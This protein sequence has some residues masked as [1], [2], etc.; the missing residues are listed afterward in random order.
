MK[1]DR[2]FHALVVVVDDRVEDRLFLESADD[3]HLG[4][5]LV[6]AVQR[7]MA[8]CEERFPFFVGLIVGDHFL[9]A[10]RV[11]GQTPGGQRDGLVDDT[12]FH[13]RID[14]ADEAGGITAGVR[15][16]FA[17]DDVLPVFERQ[18]R[19]PVVPGRIRAVR[20]RGVDDLRL[21]V[22]DELH[23]FNGG[24]VRQTQEHEVCR[25]HE[26]FPLIDV[27]MEFIGDDE[28]FDVVSLSETVIDLQ[29]CGACLTV[30]VDL[31][32]HGILPG[33]MD[34]CYVL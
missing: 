18:F 7:I 14:D 24:R 33:S 10:A 3:L 4:D 27:P 31:R 32:F 34:I 22:L 8:R 13:E 5:V 20:G 29:A 23:G 16:P 17:I 15:D 26:L 6:I 19:E 11:A 30:D 25:V 1:R 12:E 2:H 21:G 28:Q 9:A